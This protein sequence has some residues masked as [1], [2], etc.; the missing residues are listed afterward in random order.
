MK[1]KKTSE[2]AVGI[3]LAGDWWPGKSGGCGVNRN[4]GKWAQPV[5]HL[6][7]PL[8]IGTMLTLVP[9]VAVLLWL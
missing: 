4:C 2:E 3:V 5:E 9:E 6:L 7:I 1:N 8:S